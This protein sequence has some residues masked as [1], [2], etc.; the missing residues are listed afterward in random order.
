MA[1]HGIVGSDR[2]MRL[3]SW[4]IQIREYSTRK[5]CVSRRTCLAKATESDHGGTKTKGRGRPGQRPARSSFSRDHQLTWP[6]CTCSRTSHIRS[7][8]LVC[9][10]RQHS[11]VFAGRDAAHAPCRPRLAHLLRVRPAP[12]LPSAERLR[13]Q[14]EWAW[15]GA[16]RRLLEFECRLTMKQNVYSS[17]GAAVNALPADNS[18]QVVFVYPGTYVEQVNVTRGGQTTVCSFRLRSGSLRLT[19]R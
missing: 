9:R 12:D 7:N 13:S 17:V 14:K 4:A 3:H 1:V 5:S 6:P 10:C 19:A 16:L 2:N 11:A 15:K 18:S 8:R